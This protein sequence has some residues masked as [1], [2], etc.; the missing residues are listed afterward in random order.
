MKRI[1]KTRKTIKG[2]TMALALSMALSGCSFGSKTNTIT[3]QNENA[4]EFQ[5]DDIIEETHEHE[6]EQ[7]VIHEETHEDEISQ[8]IIDEAKRKHIVKDNTNDIKTDKEVVVKYTED[9]MYDING[10][11]IIPDLS[12]QF[13]TKQYTQNSIIK[14]LIL[15]GYNHSYEYRAL[16]AEHF[17][18]VRYKGTAKQNLL[19]LHFLRHPELWKTQENINAQDVVQDNGT[20]NIGQDSGNSQDN[21]NGNGNNDGNGN[22]G[23]DEKPEKPEQKGKWVLVSTTYEEIE[24]DDNFHYEVKTFK[25]SKTGKIKVERNKLAHNYENDECRDCHHKKV[26][27][28]D[29]HEF[30]GNVTYK[31][32]DKDD[33]VHTVEEYQYCS[34]HNAVELKKTYDQGHTPGD[35]IVDPNNTDQEIQKCTGCSHILDR[36]PA[37]G[38]HNLVGNVR[39]EYTDIT[40]ENHTKVGYQQCTIHNKEEEVSRKV[41]GHTPGEWAVDPSNN[42][43]LIQKCTGCGHVLDKKP[44]QQECDHKN[45]KTEYEYSFVNENTHNVV[46]VT[47]CLDCDE[48]ISR[49]EPVSGMHSPTSSVPGSVKPNSGTADGHIVEYTNTYSCCGEHKVDKSVAHG[50]EHHTDPTTTY[51]NEG[52][53]TADGK[54]GHIVVTGYTYDCGYTYTSPSEGVAITACTNDGS[55]YCACGREM[56]HIHTWVDVESPEFDADIYCSYEVKRCSECGEEDV[57]SVKHSGYYRDFDEPSGRPGFDAIR[58]GSCGDIVDYAEE[59]KDYHDDTYGDH[60]AKSG[61]GLP[62]E[63]EVKTRQQEEAESAEEQ[64][65]PVVEEEIADDEVANEE[66]VVTEEETETQ[67]ETETEEEI[68]TEEEN[69]KEDEKEVEKT[70]EELYNEFIE[71]V[72]S[73]E[74]VQTQSSEENGPERTLV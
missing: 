39:Y 18:I 56:T 2:L 41:E 15:A 48:E 36:R 63:Q 73:L 52:I 74:S 61:S 55:G 11:L 20:I 53:T 32:V 42:D 9:D 40:D 1:I 60:K 50:D 49:S 64:N 10:N 21:S 45:T 24:N 44:V 7:E 68:E 65:I 51:K 47:I 8:D 3:D 43:Q 69:E 70:T 4:Y 72:S 58:C 19:L 5:T 46:T 22:S 14:A 17:G 57:K 67:E 31:Y 28:Q 13:N 59:G 6:H 33:K 34:T 27:E 66:E 30:I 29:K 25:H 23:K 37:K 12:V 26:K 71:Y 62:E 16:L 38:K 35:W 54:P